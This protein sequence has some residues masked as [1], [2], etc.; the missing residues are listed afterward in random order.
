MIQER[1]NVYCAVSCMNVD[2][3]YYGFVFVIYHRVCR[4]LIVLDISK[5]KVLIRFIW[6]V[7][8][9]G[10]MIVLKHTIIHGQTEPQK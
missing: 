3:G 10:C 6:R 4:H 5:S 8:L 7:Y 9:Y 2:G 1:F